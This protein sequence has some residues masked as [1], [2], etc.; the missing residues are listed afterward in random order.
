MVGFFDI[1]DLH[2]DG[3]TKLITELGHVSYAWNNLHADLGDLFGSVCT[4]KGAD[5]LTRAIWHSHKS[6]SGARFMF[7]AAAVAK[8]TGDAPCLEELNWLVGEV[9]QIAAHRNDATHTL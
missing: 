9:D 4:G 7:R 5:S 8:I 1:T 2:G 6:E 3:F